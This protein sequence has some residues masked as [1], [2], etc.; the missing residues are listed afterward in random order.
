MAHGR[1]TNQGS[2]RSPREKRSTGQRSLVSKG[3][4]GGFDGAKASKCPDGESVV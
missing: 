4:A 1:K 2:S 3:L